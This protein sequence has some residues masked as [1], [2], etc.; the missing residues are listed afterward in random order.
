M[1]RHATPRTRHWRRNL[2]LTGA[3]LAVWFIVTFVVSYFARELDFG[4]FGWP[5]SFWVAS[6]GAPIVYVLIVVGYAWA[7]RREDA[8]LRRGE[9]DEPEVSAPAA[10]PPRPPAEPPMGF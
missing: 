3:L 5:F 6:Q 9:P 7:M 10:A 4:F 8:R 2:R 1:P